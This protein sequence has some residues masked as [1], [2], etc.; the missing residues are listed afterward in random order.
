[1]TIYKNEHGKRTLEKDYEE[2]IETLGFDVER[3]YVN[4]SYGRT[5]VLAAGPKDA[6]PVFIFQGGN[7]I[8]PMT[9]SW[10]SSLAERYRIYAPDTIGHP[11]FSE[12]ARVSAQDA[13]FPEWAKQLM[14]HFQIRSC[15]FI[16]PSYGGGIIM[17]MAAYMPDLIDCAVLVSPAGISLGSKTRMIKDI[18]L[19]MVAYKAFSSEKHLDKLT[20]IMSGGS[21]KVRDKE[22]IGNVFKYVKLEQDMPKITERHELAGYQAPT[23]VIAGKKD[24]FFPEQKLNRAAKEI[25][26]NLTDFKAYEMGHFPSDEYLIKINEDIIAFLGAYY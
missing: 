7:C 3:M 18:L 9:L 23:L 13:S 15:A 2:Y 8:N 6:K 10:F 16:G 26:P 24:V 12:E 25:I 1:M 20:G 5:H 22:I 11:G 14:A 19:P 21:M 4:T 17:R